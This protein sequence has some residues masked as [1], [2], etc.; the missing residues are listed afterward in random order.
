MKPKIFFII[1]LILQINATAQ[2]PD[3]IFPMDIPVVLSASFAELRPNHF[4]AGLD[5]STSGVI[6]VEVKSVADGY[7]SRIKLSPFGYGHG[8]YITHYDG[9][10]TVYG[11]LSKYAAK[12]DSVVMREQYKNKTFDVD[13]YPEK[14]EIT[15]KRGEVIAFSGNTGSSGGPHLHF[16]VRDTETDAA[17]NPL[18]FIGKVAD[19]R[20][21]V[22]S[23]IKIYPLSDSSQVAGKCESKYFTLAE[24]QGKTIESYGKLGFGINADDYFSVGG[25]PC[26]VVEVSLYDNDKLIFQSRLDTVPFEKTR[27]IN[28]MID[29]V[30]Y[31]QNKRYIQKSFVEDNNQLKI[32]NNVKDFFVDNLETH[33][34]K[35]QLKDF[36]GNVKKVEFTIKGKKNPIANPPNFNGE[37]VSWA[38][39]TFFELDGMSV[40]IPAGSFYKDEYITISKTDSSVFKQPIFTVGST[41]IPL[42]TEMD[43]TLPIPEKIKTLIENGLP[44]KKYFI[45]RIG[46]KNTLGYVGG[47]LDSC[48][49]LTVKTR[50]MGDFVVAVDTIAPNIT[51]KNS[52]TIFTNFGKILIG[53][54]DNFSG[55]AKYN[56]YIDNEWKVFEYDYKNARL[57]APIKKLNLAAG[58][59]T[60]KVEVE[61]KCENLKT[62][63]WKFRKR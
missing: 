11:H 27:Y 40:F 12:I 36:V 28:S 42:Q 41:E 30:D 47:E 60:L 54:T 25:R 5:I 44:E 23:G 1:L 21:P 48:N 33:K 6:G 45:A 56:C 39:D 18:K 49:N 29:Y 62:F 52:S 15:V 61:D 4:H 26:G 2:Q 43:L 7:V 10:T 59:H 17:L 24:I 58:Y 9:H 63:E 20:P 3:Y 35:Y 31:Q 46:K 32:Y 38:C 13:Y 50:W 51:N 57:V 53:I 8:L 19:D 37:Y 22:V 16:E 55:I 14:D 34:L